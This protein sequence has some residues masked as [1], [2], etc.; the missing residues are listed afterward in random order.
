MNTTIFNTDK[1]QQEITALLA[2]CNYQTAKPIAYSFC[3]M[4][5]NILGIKSGTDQFTVTSCLPKD[6][7][8]V[9]T[10]A[11]VT[12][13]TGSDNKEQGSV[14]LVTLAFQRSE[15]WDPTFQ[16]IIGGRQARLQHTNLHHSQIC[17]IFNPF[18]PHP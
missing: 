5:G 16:N 7:E 6:S 11:K 13:T 15:V 9:F 17:F 4:Q 10:G 18:I 12:I 3:D 1:L 14:A 2:Q 8:P